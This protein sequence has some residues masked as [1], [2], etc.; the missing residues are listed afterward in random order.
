MRDALLGRT[1]GDLDFAVGGGL[2]P[3]V[4]ALCRRFGGRAIRLGGDRFAAVRIVAAGC[5]LDLWDRGG[6]PL[7]DDLWRRD[8]TVNAMALDPVTCEPTDPTGGLPDLRRGTL[9]AT[10]PEVFGEDPLRVLRLARLR[11]ELPGFAADR[12]TLACAREASRGL[13]G[14]A[15]ER[16]REELLRLLAAPD[17]A[18]GLSLLAACGAE[19]LFGDSSAPRVAAAAA[20]LSRLRSALARLP[21][22]ALSP[23]QALSLRLALLAAALGGSAAGGRNHL[24]ELTAHRWLPRAPARDAARLLEETGPP[25]DLSEARRFLHRTGAL[26]AAAAARFAVL[27]EMGDAEVESLAAL[28]ARAG[29]DLRRPRPLLPGEEIARL[30][31]ARPGPELGGWIAL[32]RQAEV[33]GE[34]TDP[35]SARAWLAARS[36]GETGP[37]D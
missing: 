11:A 33:A 31:G 18:G 12:A 36:G 4:A 22:L 6:G 34:V 8:L 27:A 37:R 23:G 24:E 1:A 19:G 26:W 2:E 35:E 20:T 29:T 3:L 28:E 17:A 25:R 30:T 9:R 7:A 16:I 15:A 32:L 21:Q 13:A 14:I 5:A 10:R